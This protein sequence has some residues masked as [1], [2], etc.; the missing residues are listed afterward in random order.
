MLLLAA[1]LGTTS[2]LPAQSS[3]EKVYY[4]YH[5]NEVGSWKTAVEELRKD[6]YQKGKPHD[7]H[8]YQLIISEYGLIGACQN[9]ASCNDVAARIARVER[10][11]HLLAEEAK[12]QGI[13]QALEGG[14]IALK[15]NEAPWKG[16]TLAGESLSKIKAGVALAPEEPEPWIEL[17]N[18]RSHAP[19]LFGGDQAAAIKAYEKAIKLYEERPESERHTWLYLHALA[20]LGQAYV[21]DGQPHQGKAIYRKAL[22][23]EPNFHLVKNVL[24][25]LAK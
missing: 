3:L 10:Y 11:L 12:F 25:P 6:W 8:L 1:G 15:I 22:Q 14:L 16:V 9:G 17:G 23:L 18:F 13:A 7:H 21:A 19:D 5:H 4:A 24:L 20:S 2:L